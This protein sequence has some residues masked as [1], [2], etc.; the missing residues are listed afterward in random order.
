MKRTVR[1]TESE[2][3]RMI[4]ESVKKVLKG[5]KHRS[6]NEGGHLYYKD[7]EG[8]IY[9]NSK[10]RYRGVPGT[11]F[12]WHGEWSDPEV[13]YKGQSINANDIEETLWDTYCD[14]CEENGQKPTNNGFDEWVEQMG[15]DYVAA[16]LDEFV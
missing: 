3:K 12:I 4:S 8:N 11:T 14:E 5:I 7:D 13:I 2:L 16:T 10:D 1:L 9:T 15:T 6:L